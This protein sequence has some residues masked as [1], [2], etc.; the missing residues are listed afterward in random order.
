[1]LAPIALYPTERRDPPGGCEIERRF[2][3]LHIPPSLEDYPHVRIVQGYLADAPNTVRVRQ[4]GDDSFFLTLKSG[5][6]PVRRECEIALTRAQFE[7]LWPLTAGRRLRK[8]RYRIPLEDLTIELDVFE[9]VNRGVL[10]AEVEFPDEISCAA[11]Q[12][13]DWLG[14][15]V[16]GDPQY[17]NRRMATE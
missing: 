16:S 17:A 7:K 12:P 14:R 15:D 9:G 1:M 3:V 8:S 5:K 11:F 13:P 10:V 6:P 2:Q 4:L